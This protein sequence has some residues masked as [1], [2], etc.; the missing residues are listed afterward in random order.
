MANVESAYDQKTGAGA[1]TTAV[2]K[3]L[4]QKRAHLEGLLSPSAEICLHFTV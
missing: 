3:T 4:R 1:L 2:G